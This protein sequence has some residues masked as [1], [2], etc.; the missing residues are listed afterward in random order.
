LLAA[1]FFDAAADGFGE[2]VGLPPPA[3]FGPPAEDGEV[4]RIARERSSFVMAV[5]PAIPS[6]RAIS[7]RSFFGF[8]VRSS[9]L[10]ENS[11]SLSASAS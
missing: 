7:S 9:A 1:V 10:I 11:F 6:F 5:L 4:F 3:S 2:E 8:A